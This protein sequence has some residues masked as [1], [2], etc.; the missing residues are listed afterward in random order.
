[1]LDPGAEYK[2]NQ[3]AHKSVNK[4]EKQNLGIISGV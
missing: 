4:P 2:Y 1:M 3:P